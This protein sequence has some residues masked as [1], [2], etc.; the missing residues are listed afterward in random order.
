MNKNLS[1]KS[2]KK[3]LFT[4]NFLK[5]ES[6]RNKHQCIKEPVIEV[7]SKDYDQINFNVRLINVINIKY[8]LQV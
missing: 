6:E 1:N 5:E 4:N 7:N 3:R 8:S 2:I